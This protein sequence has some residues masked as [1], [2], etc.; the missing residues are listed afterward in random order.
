MEDFKRL[1]ISLIQTMIIAHSAGYGRTLTDSETA[2][3]D[4]MIG[5]LRQEMKFRKEKD[6]IILIA[7]KINVAKA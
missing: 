2:D 7:E 4:A 3:R 6:S 1:E 5:K